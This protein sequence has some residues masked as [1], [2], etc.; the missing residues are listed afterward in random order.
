MALMHARHFE[1]RVAASNRRTIWPKKKPNQHKRAHLAIQVA[2]S[3]TKGT[4][5]TLVLGMRERVFRSCA[6]KYL[7]C[8][9]DNNHHNR[10][11]RDN[12]KGSVSDAFWINILGN[13][14]SVEGR[15]CR[16]MIYTF[17]SNRASEEVSFYVNNGTFHLDS[18]VKLQRFDWD[19]SP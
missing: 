19:Q 12:R 13:P 14:F 8:S 16:T 11:R 15:R 7:S 3:R 2:A 4:R 18:D 6:Y 5:P 1:N 10:N 9:L 17:P